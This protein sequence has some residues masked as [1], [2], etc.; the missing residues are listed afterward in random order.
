MVPSVSELA[1][2]ARLRRARRIWAIASVHGDSSRLA[3][4][5]DALA[6]RLE[7]GDRLVYLGNLL[8]HGPD[9]RGAVNEAIRF[10]RA[11]I[12]RPGAFA[13]DVVFLRGCQ[14]E[15]WQKLLSLQL[16]PKPVDV[17][18]WMLD[19]GVAATI[20]AYGGDAAEGLAAARSGAVAIARWT[21]ALRERFRGEP[22]HEPL[23]TALK[24]AALGT[25]DGV[26]FVSAGIDVSKPLDAQGDSFWW[27]GTAFN[28]I[29]GYDGF[30]RIVRGHDRA[31]SGLKVAAATVS[32]DGGAG[33]GGPLLACAVAPDG[34]VL[35]VLQA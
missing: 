22:G 21:G 33:F 3:R 10:R 17:L 5:H 35:E 34:E 27:G 8:G 16:A 26:L 20:A 4:L 2:I 24:R 18:T 28:A 6:P 25:G 1:A 30:K 31:R 19:H 23:L 9:P 13:G 15:M 7:R 11:V 32:L 14:E 29:A 12:A